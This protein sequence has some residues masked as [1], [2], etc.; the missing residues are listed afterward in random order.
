MSNTVSLCLK[1]PLNVNVCC[2]LEALIRES[3]WDRG[4]VPVKW[5]S[6]AFCASWRIEKNNWIQSRVWNNNA[7]SLRRC[8]LI[9]KIFLRLLQ[10]RLENTQFHHLFIRFLGCKTLPSFRDIHSFRWSIQMHMVHLPSQADWAEVHQ[11]NN[12]RWCVWR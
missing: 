6:T 9:H 3:R 2:L 7:G 12:G 1:G 5:R 11:Q 10:V 4:Y 8:E